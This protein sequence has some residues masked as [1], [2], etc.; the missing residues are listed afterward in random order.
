MRKR[1][2]IATGESWRAQRSAGQ[3]FAHP[4]TLRHFAETTLARNLPV[5]LGPLDAAADADAEGGEG[6]VDFERVAMDYSMAVFGEIA[7]DVSEL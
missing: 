5:L 7:F 2:L 1:I 3:T 6:I 4:S